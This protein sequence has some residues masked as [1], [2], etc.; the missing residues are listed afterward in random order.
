[1]T[2]TPAAATT[3]D[4]HFAAL[5]RLHRLAIARCG[6]ATHDLVIGPWR[7]RLV[8]AGAGLAETL[9]GPLKRLGAP[10][11]G[12]ADATIEVWD[13]A[14][15]ETAT[16]DLPPVAASASPG[17]G[18]AE[19]G[20]APPPAHPDPNR[21]SSG[22]AL[23]RHRSVYAR[24]G[25]QSDSL[26]MFDS[27]ERIGRFWFR[28]GAQIRWYERAEP[29]RTALHWA[30][31]GPDA[32]LA[33][34]SAVGDERGAVVL[35]GRGGTGKTTTTLAALDAG[36]RFVGDNYVLVSVRE[37]VPRVYGLF[38]TA[39]LWPATLEQLPQLAP[40]V[41][42]H[43]VARDEKLVADIAAHRP[44]T[45]ATGLPVR[46][47]VVPEVVGT[48]PARMTPCSPV[49]ALLAMAP[50]TMLQLPRTDRGF[51][52]MAELVRRVPTYRLQLGAELRDGP[53]ALSD[54]LA[55]VGS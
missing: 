41:L 22:I 26:A 11:A 31:T 30:L 37:P 6:T 32:Y 20:L 44:E 27:R 13:S 21:P 4:G 3:P 42:T 5:G 24:E 45:L 43:K 15:S 54:L 19:P 23:P 17:P 28:D 7:I 36:L 10:V 48:G 47:V 52:G 8:F 34:A 29:L 1:M 33:H 35:T 2:A 49:Q 38:G 16:P 51:A 39:K 9:L 53:R 40:L 46:A 50:A 55:E 18:S 12:T 14:G 25:D